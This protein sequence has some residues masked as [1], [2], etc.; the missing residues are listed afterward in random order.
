MDR[1]RQDDINSLKKLFKEISEFIS[2][3][4]SGEDDYKSTED[5]ENL[6]NINDSLFV[7]IYSLENGGECKYCQAYWYNLISKTI[8]G[9]GNNDNLLDDD[10][11]P[12]DEDD[13]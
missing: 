5:Y 11:F 8:Y 12:I 4:E 1:K 7:Y 3:I 9:N 10:N 6:K 13:Y 2:K